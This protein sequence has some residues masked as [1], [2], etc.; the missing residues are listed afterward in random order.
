MCLYSRHD[1]FKVDKQVLKLLLAWLVSCL[2]IQWLPSPVKWNTSHE[3]LVQ[4]FT[5]RLRQDN[6]HSCGSAWE[7]EQVCVCV[8][9]QLWKLQQCSLFSEE[10]WF[11]TFWLP[12][13]TTI[14]K[15]SMT[16]PVIH[17]FYPIRYSRALNIFFM[18]LINLSKSINHTFI[19]S[20]FFTLLIPFLQRKKGSISNVCFVLF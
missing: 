16:F 9:Q 2:F 19:I 4:W 8:E 13:F 18:Y 14:F 6:C 20:K 15:C 17:D 11:S 10:L 1:V 7:R 5:H 3:W 12:L